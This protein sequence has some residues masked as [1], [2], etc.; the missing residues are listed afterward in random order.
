MKL[1]TLSSVIISCLVLGIIP[2]Q[3]AALK[4]SNSEKALGTQKRIS[5]HKQVIAQTRKRLKP[6]ALYPQ[7]RLIYIEK[8]PAP[9]PN[10]SESPF[11]VP[12]CDHEGTPQA[13]FMRLMFSRIRKI[14]TAI[15][16][17]L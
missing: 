2:A 15:D 16:K 17:K 5:N 6:L 7:S 14:D 13:G 4:R 8:H 10:K 12:V 11:T 9:N 3:G 1:I